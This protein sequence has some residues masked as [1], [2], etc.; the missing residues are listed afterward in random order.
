MMGGVRLVDQPGKGKYLK[1]SRINEKYKEIISETK[2]VATTAFE[3]Y[4]FP[5]VDYNLYAGS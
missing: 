1:V 5:F 3:V 2:A 4:I